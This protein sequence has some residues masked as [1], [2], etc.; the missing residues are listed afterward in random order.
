MSAT[1]L[2]HQRDDVPS[3]FRHHGL[4]APGVRAFR[5]MGFPAK[6]IWVSLAFMLPIV[7]LMASLWTSAT[8]NIEFSAKE[9]LGV[10]YGR[11]L[12]GVLDAAQNR[13]RAATV[14]AADL[15]EAQERVRHSMQTLSDVH[16]TLSPDLPDT[17]PAWQSVQDLNEALMAQPV[18]ADA[19]QTFAAHTAFVDAVMALLQDVM[20]QSNLTLDPDVD[21]YY[22][23][24][25]ALFKQPHL[26][27]Q[28]GKMRGLGNKLIAMGEKSMTQH[29]VMS[30]AYAFAATYQEG[31]EQALKRAIEADPR[32]ASEVDVRAAYA[33]SERFL[34]QVLQQVLA[35]TPSGDAASYVAAANEAIALHYQAIDHMLTA[36]DK[37]LVAR[38]TRLQHILWMQLGIALAGISLAVYMLVAFYRVTQGGIAEV[39]RQLTEI[40]RGNLTLHPR[41][42]GRDEVAELMNTLAATLTAL[43]RIVG[44][45]RR[46]ADEIQTASQEVALASQDLSRRTEEAAAQL[47]R[48]SAD[49]SH[50]GDTVQQSAHMATGVSDIVVHNAQVAEKGGA[51]VDQVVSTMAEIRASSARIGEIIRTID[52][53]AFQTNILAL[54]A[55]VEAARSGEQGRGFAVVASEVR[56]LAK[57]SAEAASEIKALIGASVDQVADGAKLVGQAGETIRQIV[58]H[59]NQVKQLITEIGDG[60]RTQAGRVSAVGQSVSQLDSMTQQ[61]AALVEQTAA[62]AASLS[63]NAARLNEEMAFFTV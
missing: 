48:T 58:S 8:Q 61:N 29:D 47:Q 43:R 12:M 42:W 20:D 53:I 35:P 4:M 38:V 9:R 41:P 51:E 23:M 24:D 55:A 49:M 57:R 52:S 25:A 45:V 44:Q 34:G 46:S 50:I 36:L 16:Q 63:D 30:R 13:R 22:L 7:V 2:H 60:T 31:A 56:A 1:G 39:A 5:R 33:A 6:A 59:A 32:V 28:M 3:F 19:N 18:K 54:N 62:S 37:R 15:T 27:E 17:V 11:A 26:I 21:T 14:Q 10:S 40:S